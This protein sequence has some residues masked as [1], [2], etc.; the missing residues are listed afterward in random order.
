MFLFTEENRV[1]VSKNELIE[2]MTAFLSLL[3]SQCNTR[4]YH[5]VWNSIAENDIACKQ[6]EKEEINK[7]CVKSF[8]GCDRV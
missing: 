1:E 7:S 4:S 5:D 3:K 6:D 8:F 2:E